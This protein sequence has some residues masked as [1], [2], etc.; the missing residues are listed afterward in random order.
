M[1]SMTYG[2]LPTREALDA[3]FLAACPSDRYELVL[4]GEDRATFARAEALARER[5]FDEFM[6]NDHGHWNAREFF[7]AVDALRTLWDERGDDAAGD[8]ASSLLATIG[9][10]WI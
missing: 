7:N 5:Q 10:E 4:K 9:I 6:G 8:L 2:T 1:R 3:L